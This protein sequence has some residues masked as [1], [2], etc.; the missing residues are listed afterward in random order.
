MVSILTRFKKRFERMRQRTL[1]RSEKERKFDILLTL[2][3][4][5]SAPATAA[6]LS[7]LMTRFSPIGTGVISSFEAAAI[8]IFFFSAIPTLT[9]LYFYKKGVV[10]IEISERKKRTPIYLASIASQI[11][12]ALVFYALEAKIMFILSIAYVAV[13]AVVLII[14]TQWK[15]SAH[16]SGM[17]G[18]ATA[19]YMVFG[20]TALPAFLFL[21]PV[22]ALRL[23]LKA[24]DI[25]QLIAGAAVSTAVTYT[26]YYIAFLP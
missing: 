19:L 10:D 5:C 21:I 3:L 9:A 14:N 20:P 1:G 6:I 2:S 8:G 23:K 22:F 18:P 13:T 4:I 25:W 26:V 17:A 15:V 16:T 24:H 7:I 11:L 12:A